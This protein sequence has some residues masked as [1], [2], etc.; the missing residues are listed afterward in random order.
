MTQPKVSQVR[1]YRLQNSSLE[2]LMQA[3]ARMSY[4]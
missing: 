3:L 2:Q 1:R 4:H